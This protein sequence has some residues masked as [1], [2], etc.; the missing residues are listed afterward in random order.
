MGSQDNIIDVFDEISDGDSEIASSGDEYVP[1]MSDTSDSDEN[2]PST[3]N[4][5]AAP[6]KNKK[7]KCQISDDDPDDNI[8]LSSLK[9]KIS[10]Q[11]EEDDLE[12]ISQMLDE[13]SWEDV[14]I[15][16][17]DTLFKGITEQ[18]PEGGV[19]TPYVYFRDLITD[20]MLE[21]VELQS[22][23]YALKKSGIELKTTK[24]EVEIFIG[25]YL[26]M[27][28]MKA[29]CVRAYWAADTRYPPVAD[30]LSRNRFEVLARHIHFCKNNS[31][32]EEQMKAD[33]I[34]KVRSWVD[35]FRES[36][37]KIAPLQ[38]QSVD[39]VM[40]AFKGR[41][42]LKQYLRNKPRKWGFKLWARAGSDGILHDF[43]IY[44][45]KRET[46]EQSSGLGMTGDVVIDMIKKLPDGQ[47]FVIFADNLFSSLKLVQELTKRGF[48]YVGTVREN[49]LKGCHLKPE[50]DLKTEKR[51]ALDRKT[52]LNSNIVAVRWFDNRKVDLI[53]SCVGVEPVKKVS[54]YDKK[55]KQ[56]VE[57]PCPAIVDR[58]NQ[59][60]GGVDLLDS[61]TSL[62]KYGLKSRRW[63]IYIFLHTVNMAVVSA[64]LW[65]RRHCG[66]QKVTHIKL[67]DFQAQI[68]TCCV[69]TQRLPGRPSLDSGS[70]VAQRSNGRQRNVE[71]VPKDVRFDQV[72]HSP[73][74]S[75][76][77]RCKTDCPGFTYL[78]CE[79][80]KKHL[81]INKDRN[82][83]VKYHT[84]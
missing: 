13:P 40:V 73:I 31:F 63:Y 55:A 52:E 14:D 83:F 26:R 7:R 71:Q 43:D 10:Q 30:V 64:W 66:L 41:S 70:P 15:T 22:N 24:K 39:E 21:N 68:A 42:G 8:P 20:A 17:V 76:R 56:I 4:T 62:Y 51:G 6:T 25:L 74:W 18:L 82:C 67:S 32:T 9:Q 78:Y 57:I 44:Q 77:G 38:N 48:W 58:Y 61:L 50:K 79:K 46:T 29:H 47:N 54:R 45:G 3:S 69:K 59:N 23:N 53:S 37:T 34:W 12:I 65:Y 27:G 35:G 1:S 19:K 2:H 49:R 5:H 84:K 11:R 60:M 36:L 16:N 33:K 72:G 28:L 80:C 81:C 75:V